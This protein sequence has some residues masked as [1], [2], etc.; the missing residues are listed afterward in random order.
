MIHVMLLMHDQK[1][2]QRVQTMTNKIR[3]HDIY[4]TLH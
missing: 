1:K 4:L 2:L 3:D